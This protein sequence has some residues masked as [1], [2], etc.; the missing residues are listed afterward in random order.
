MFLYSFAYK[1]VF[2]IKFTAGTHGVNS[3]MYYNCILNSQCFGHSETQVRPTQGWGH[4]V[5]F[6]NKQL[7]LDFMP[8]LLSSIVILAAS[9]RWLGGNGFY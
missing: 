1:F 2:S 8:D 9:Q 6:L 4:G 3:K 5:R 7:D